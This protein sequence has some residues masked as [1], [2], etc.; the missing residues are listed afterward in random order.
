MSLSR[1]CP[2]CAL[3]VDQDESTCSYC[4][5][6][7]PETSNSVRWVAWLMAALLVWPLIELFKW[8]F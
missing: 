4:G 5:Y 1:E 7:F 6:E 3:S 8:I 2:S